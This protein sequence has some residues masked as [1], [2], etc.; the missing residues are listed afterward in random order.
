MLKEAA[1]KVDLNP[2]FKDFQDQVVKYLKDN[3][4]SI[5]K[6][7]MTDIF[8]SGMSNFMYD[9]GLT[10]RMREEFSMQINNMQ[11]QTDQKIHNALS[12]L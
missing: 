11:N 1:R 9:S 8:I 3:H 4:D 5:I 10:R 2:L 6:E 12:Q 7:L